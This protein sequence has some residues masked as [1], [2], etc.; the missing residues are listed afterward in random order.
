MIAK[1]LKV[2]V[3]CPLSGKRA[4]YTWKANT[5][6]AFCVLDRT[7]RVRNEPRWAAIKKTSAI[8][9]PEASREA[10]QRGTSKVI[11]NQGDRQA[12]YRVNRCLMGFLVC[13]RNLE[14]R[15]ERVVEP[16]KLQAYHP[17][18][19]YGENKMDFYMMYVAGM[20]RPKKIHESIETARAAVQAYKDEGGTRE[21]YILKT[22]EKYPGRKLL[23]IKPKITV[24]PKD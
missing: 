23:T 6:G 3:F 8:Q 19:N 15:W 18:G 22:V 24:E 14:Y 12:L 11:G 2:L 13:N 1:A 17:W 10:C 16:R 5:L 4:G 21:C 20:R 7:G 9:H